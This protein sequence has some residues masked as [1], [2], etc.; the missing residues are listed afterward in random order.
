[1][2]HPNID[3]RQQYVKSLLD[4]GVTF[5]PKALRDVA[6]MF[7]C[8]TSAVRADVISL[9]KD[10]NLPSIYVSADMRKRIRKRDGRVCQYCGTINSDKEYVVEHVIPAPQGPA[11]EYN[12]VIACQACNSKKGS[13]VWI[14]H[15]IGMI[16][17]DHPGWKEK[18][19]NLALPDQ[20]EFILEDTNSFLEAREY[21][22]KLYKSEEIKKV[23]GEIVRLLSR[24]DHLAE[25]H[26]TVI[27]D[28]LRQ[29]LRSILKEVNA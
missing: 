14:P 16:T 23:R 22:A 15:N 4:Q 5:D 12:L 24:A 9:T 2:A 27:T 1:M 28:D 21:Y 29:S 6:S 10:P 20:P 7:N 11:R 25:K 17:L 18:I 13:S 8:H 26:P 3:Q 19:L